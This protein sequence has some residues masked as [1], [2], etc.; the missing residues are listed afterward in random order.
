M[1]MSKLTF[2]ALLLL[3]CVPL[4]LG[5]GG[6]YTQIDFPGAS[7]TYCEGIDKAGDIVGGYYVGGVLHGFLLSPRVYTTID[8]PGAGTTVALG[9]NDVGQIVG[10]ADDFSTM[11]RLRLTALFTIPVAPRRMRRPLTTPEQSRA[12]LSISQTM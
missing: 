8:Y 5:Q 6:T 3:A 1:K 9:I 2:A 4:A 7:A 10:Q 11:N 12:S